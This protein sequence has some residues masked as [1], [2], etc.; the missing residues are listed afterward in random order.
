LSARAN[1]HGNGNATTP[2]V[3][4]PNVAGAA[5]TLP[6][7]RF[8]LILPGG[9]ARGAYQVGVL[10][11][12]AEIV[13]EPVPFTV[14][15]G[16]SVGAINAAMVACHAG[17]IAGGVRALERLWGSLHCEQVFR[18][19]VPSI[20]STVLHWLASLTFG[21]L[22]VANPRS[23]LDNRPLE[24]LLTRSLDFSGLASAIENG[25]LIAFG[26]TSSS[27]ATGRAVTFFQGA[28]HIKEWRRARREGVRK[29]VTINDLLASAALP[30]VFPPRRVADQFFGDGSLRL[31]APISPAIHLGADRILIVCARGE[32]PHS[33]ALPHKIDVPSLGVISG[34]LLDILFN[35]NLD[36]DIERLERINATISLIPAEDEEDTAL[37]KMGIFV[38]RPSSD[39]DEICHRHAHRF[40]WTIR[41]LLKGLRASGPKSPLASY[42]LFEAEYCRE[43][44]ELGYQDALRRRDVLAEFFQGS[45]DA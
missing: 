25:T 33:I 13:P 19:D 7:R 42:L 5:E 32:E 17:D 28:R 14:I 31:N 29:N 12:I 22:G 11:A 43:L 41:A 39:I 4:E 30:F 44:M 2:V 45:A 24:Q 3:E 15:A 1:D 16:V 10:K 34:A 38:Q 26:V 27:Y 36:A 35:D 20:A 8:G 9:G 6:R 23:L 40:P 37:K 21:G 18:T